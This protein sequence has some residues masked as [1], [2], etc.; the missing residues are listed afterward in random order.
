MGSDDQ[1]VFLISPDAGATWVILQT[2]DVT[3]PISNVGETVII[4]LLGY[5]QTDV[6]FAFWANEGTVNDP[7]DYD[8]FIDN[9]KVQVPP[10][11]PQPFALGVTFIAATTADLLWTSFSGLSDIEFGLAGFPPTGVPTYSG[12]VS[13]YT[14]GG[15]TT[16][17]AYSFY[18]RDDCG[19][20]DY[21]LWSGPY[22]FT[23]TASCPPPF[24]LGA[25][26]ITMT[27]ADLLWTSFTNLSDVEFGPGGFTPTGV[28]TYS[29]VISP[30]NVSGLNSAS[31]YDFY[32]RDDCG[33]GDYSTWAGPYTLL[34]MP[35]SQ[36]I[37][38]YEDFENGFVYFNNA[39]GNGSDWTINNTYYHSGVQCAYNAYDNT[40]TNILHE[41]GVIDLSSAAVV[42]L[43]FWQIAKT[44]GDYDHC[45]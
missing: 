17:T 2:W 25:T 18:V 37:P 30:Y 8:F 43:E 9:F 7:E 45:Y 31:P 44:E 38:V 41:T 12:V 6:I 39:A 15:L 13:P 33:G 26:N 28:P 35:G 24:D 10:T 4:P 36:G 23:T 21:S 34:T 3:T 32:V 20:G 11:C 14:V 42:F 19:G 16:L 1:M 22:T 5:N 29:G 40:Q 27:S